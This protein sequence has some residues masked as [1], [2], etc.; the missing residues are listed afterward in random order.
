[1]T[2]A[3]KYLPPKVLSHVAYSVFA[4]LFE[5]WD[6]HWIKRRKV[7]YFQ[8]TPRLASSQLLLD[9]IEGWGQK[10]LCKY[11]DME[12]RLSS[13]SSSSSSSSVQYSR[14]IPLALI[15]GTKD[16]LVDGEAF[17]R[18]FK[19]YEQHGII[20]NEENENNNDNNSIDEE[21]E[22]IINENTPIHTK[23]HSCSFP[24]LELVHVERIEGYEHMDTLWGSDNHIT[25]YPIIFKTL[26]NGLWE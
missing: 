9:W 15:Y 3:Q 20:L 24:T 25:T 19:G 5:W 1:M 14:K 6:D 2:T 22:F 10:G 18:T 12:Y 4:Y 21:Q 16:Y 7:K 13:S 26:N 23:Q 11:V 8:Y 17:V